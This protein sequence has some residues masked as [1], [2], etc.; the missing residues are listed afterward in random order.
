MVGDTPA[1]AGAAAGGLR[2]LVLRRGPGQVH[3]LG[4][5]LRRPDWPALN[6][7]VGGNHCRNAAWRLSAP[8]R[9]RPCRDTDRLTSGGSSCR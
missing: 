2:V 1:D 6:V 7:A 9:R 3:G 5:A 8:R 4:L